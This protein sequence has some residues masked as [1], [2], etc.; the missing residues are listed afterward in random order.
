MIDTQIKR[1][2]CA[3]KFCPNIG[4]ASYFYSYHRHNPYIWQNHQVYEN[5]IQK[6]NIK[7][8]TVIKIKFKNML[9]GKPL[10]YNYKPVSSSHQGQWNRGHSWNDWHSQRIVLHAC[11]CTVDGRNAQGLLNGFEPLLSVSRL[12]SHPKL[13]SSLMILSWGP[14]VELFLSAKRDDGFRY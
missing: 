5:E 1:E 11:T 2:K 12:F 9:P 13:S 4:L 10:S 8:V 7:T 6:S 14:G 3:T